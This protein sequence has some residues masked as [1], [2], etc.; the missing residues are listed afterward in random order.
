MGLQ[1]A[2]SCP[3]RFSEFEMIVGVPVGVK[4][5]TAADHM[6]NRYRRHL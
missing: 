1:V 2:V 3:L 6:R 5:D 4:E